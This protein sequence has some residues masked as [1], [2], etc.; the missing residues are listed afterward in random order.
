MREDNKRIA[1]NT[2]MLYFRMLLSMFISL[3]TSRI[4]L[5]VL[6][7]VDYGIQN[8]VGGI[9]G[10]FSVLNSSMGGATSRFI[11]FE[12]GNGDSNKIKNIFSTALTVHIIIALVIVLLGETIGV[13][14][15]ENKLQIPNERMFAA[16][17]IYQFS[18]IGIFL[19]ITQVPYHAMLIAHER[20]DVYAKIEI[21]NSL[22]RIFN[23]IVISNVKNID[24]LI[25]NGILMLSMST[26]NI[27]IYRI[28]CI[29]KIPES[30]YAFRWCWKEVKPMLNYSGWDL[31]GNISVMARTQ[32]V[33]ML[34]NMFF[35]PIVNA[36][37]GIATQ[38]QNAVMSFAGNILS[39]FRPQIVK[40]YATGDYNRT[41]YLVIN[42]AKIC[43]VLLLLISLPLMVEMP[44]ILS[45]WLKEVPEYSV[46]FCRLTLTFNFLANM[47]SVV[48]SAIH[49]TGK[50]K[51]PSLINGTLYILVIPISYIFYKLDFAPWV[52]YAINVFMVMLGLLSNVYTLKLHMVGF[53]FYNFIKKVILPCSV[54]LGTSCITTIFSNNII[55]NNLGQF[56]FTCMI[57]TITVAI[58]S[59]FL[60]LDQEYK[61]LITSKIKNIIK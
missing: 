50:I 14:F 28:Y 17:V 35:G 38:V 58:S 39:A 1:R 44:Y 25:L 12:I 26:I 27:L 31:Y 52:S 46:I 6:G 9:I 49:A 57:S 22:L 21:L 41:T 4:I 18:I 16:R 5:D 24:T 11:T 7:V 51:R 48:I 42:A 36:A 54:V 30:R 37:S 15:L 47:S 43:F 33:S 40:S 3:F 29:R 53:G 60:I 10:M 2:M 61:T 20:M 55:G 19:S 23:I 13:W 59:Y 34:L 32:G 56:I 8:V 45:I